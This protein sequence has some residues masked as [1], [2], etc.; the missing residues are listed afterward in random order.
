MSASL[1]LHFPEFLFS[2]GSWVRVGHQR[3]SCEICK[4]DVK[5]QILFG[6]S[7]PRTGPVALTYVIA[8]ILTHLQGVDN[9]QT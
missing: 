7:H 3:N 1:G 2:I 5:K 4:T 6:L 9:S 8:D